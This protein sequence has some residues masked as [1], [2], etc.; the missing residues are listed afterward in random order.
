MGWFS[1]IFDFFKQVRLGDIERSKSELLQKQSEISEQHWRLTE[2]QL[3]VEVGDLKRL[4]EESEAKVADRDR[5]FEVAEAAHGLEVKQLRLNNEQLQLQIKKKD[6]SIELQ[7]QNIEELEKRI[8]DLE[9]PKALDD[10]ELAILQTLSRGL[11]ANAHQLA[12]VLSGEYSGIVYRLQRMA[13]LGLV[14][15]D[16]VGPQ[17]ADYGITFEG[18]DLSQKNRRRD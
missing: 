17:G 4:L 11:P 7:R 5:R 6:A 9:L 1:G 18:R 12:A 3:Q 13:R 8:H 16:S 14:R 15:S 10:S 2:K